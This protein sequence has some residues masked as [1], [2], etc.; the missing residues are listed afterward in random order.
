MNLNDQLIWLTSV[1]VLNFFF[2]G[3]YKPWLYLF[4]MSSLP[5]LYL[6]LYTYILAEPQKVLQVPAR[7]KPPKI[8][9]K[10]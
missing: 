6:E 1:N 10:P 8:W 4:T 7:P 2:F 5:E 9:L 3:E